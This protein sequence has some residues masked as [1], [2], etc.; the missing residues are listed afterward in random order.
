[1]SCYGRSIMCTEPVSIPPRTA[2]TALAPPPHIVD[3]SCE[4][5]MEFVRHC[6]ARLVSA[7]ELL[8]ESERGVPMQVMEYGDQGNCRGII[9]SQPGAFGGS[10][11]LASSV[12]DATYGVERIYHWGY[13]DRNFGNDRG[14]CAPP[15]SPCG[16]YGGNIWVP[17][18]AGHLFGTG[19]D[20]ILAPVNGNS[21]MSLAADRDGPI[22]ASGLGGWGKGNELRL[23]LSL[24]SPDKGNHTPT[25]VSIEFERSSAW[26]AAGAPLPPMRRK[27]MVLNRTKRCVRRDLARGSGEGAA[28]QQY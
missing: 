19:N 13:G 4:Y 24:F 21:S 14:K 10:W 11:T 25:V 22:T 27:S 7:R 15:L 16:L 1:M 6:A 12:T 18:A 5:N 9:D 3:H 8:P 26:G 2:L 28:G 20:T 17:A 23:L